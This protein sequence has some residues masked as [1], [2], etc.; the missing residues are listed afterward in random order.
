MNSSIIRYILGGILKMEAVLML[1]PCLVAL[2]YQEK[3]GMWYMTVA[4]ICL[5]L[6]I[7]MSLRK[8]KTSVF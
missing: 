5:V 2:L 3:E 4:G 1:L 7:L 6:G 8:T